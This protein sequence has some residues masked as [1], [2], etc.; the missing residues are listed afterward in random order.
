[1]MHES[2]FANVNTLTNS[3][4]KLGGAAIASFS[5]HCSYNRNSGRAEGQKVQVGYRDFTHRNSC[6][7]HLVKADLT[8]D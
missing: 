1:M 6:F 2:T 3:R 7:S 5:D 8:E 4:T